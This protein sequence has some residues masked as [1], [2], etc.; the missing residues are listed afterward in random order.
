MAIAHNMGHFAIFAD[1]YEYGVLFCTLRSMFSAAASI[2][3]RRLS[4]HMHTET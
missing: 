4:V 3:L 2:T 1:W